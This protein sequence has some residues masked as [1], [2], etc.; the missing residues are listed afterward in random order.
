MKR[1]LAVRGTLVALKIVVDIR[2]HLR[3]HQRLTGGAESGVSS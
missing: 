2:F 1:I 3:E